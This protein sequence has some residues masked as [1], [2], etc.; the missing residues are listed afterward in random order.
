MKLGTIVGCCS[1]PTTSF[2]KHC[3]RTYI[4]P[5]QILSVCL[6]IDRNLFHR[7]LATEYSKCGHF[8]MDG[9]S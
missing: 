4:F 6:P 9:L 1:G 7:Q 2:R 3:F 8:L 5:L